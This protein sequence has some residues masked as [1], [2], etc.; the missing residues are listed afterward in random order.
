MAG[1]IFETAVLGEILKR[2]LH[3]GEAPRIH[4]WRTSTGHEVDFLVERAGR[5]VP[6]EAK[7]TS[8]PVPS[9]AAP[10]QALVRELG[11]R[12]LSGYVVHGG[13]HLLP[14]GG[15]VTAVPLA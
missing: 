11:D 8:T 5:L 7:A 10:I 15:G 3:R 1:A 6:V 14:L 4:F 13:S 9:H 2:L 12:L